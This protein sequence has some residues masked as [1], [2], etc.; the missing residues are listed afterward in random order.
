MADIIKNETPTT[1]GDPA[2]LETP[3]YI[4]QIQAGDTLYDIATHHGIKFRNGVADNTGTT[5]NGTTD[6]EV[7]IPTI[8]ELVQSPIQFVGTVGSEGTIVYNEGITGDPKSGYLVFITVDCTF[9]EI[10]CEARDMA[11]YDGAKWHVVT[12]ENQVEIMGVSQ[13]SNAANV[14][15][16]STAKEVLEVEGKTLKLS[17]DY[18]GV[19]DKLKVSK[20]SAATFDV[21]GT[22]TVKSKF[23]TLTAGE[24]SELTIGEKY[25]LNIPTGLTSGTVSFGELADKSF[26]TK[27]D[28]KITD[29]SL[30]TLKTNAETI[31]ITVE[32]G[33]LTVVATES[34]SGNVITGAELSISNVVTGISEDKNNSKTFL[35]GWHKKATEGD[36]ST[37]TAD[38]KYI[39]TAELGGTTTFFASL[40]D[41]DAQGANTIVSSITGGSVT[42]KFVTG[43]GEGI[44]SVVTSITGGDV[45]LA[46]GTGILTGLSTEGDSG[47]VVSNCTIDGG[48][49]GDATTTNVL[50]SATVNNHVLSFGTSAVVSEQ[51]TYTKPTITTKY[52]TFS[53]SKLQYTAPTIT[54]SNFTTDD[55]KYTA[56]APTYKQL[57]TGT[58]NISATPVEFMWN[59][60]T[61]SAYTPVT[62]D[63]SLNLAKAN[64]TVSKPTITASIPANSVVTGFM[65]EGAL[66]KV[67][68]GDGTNLS[69]TV[70]TDLSTET[71]EFYIVGEDTTKSI[72]IPGAYSLG[73]SDTQ[74]AE[75]ADYVE[76]GAAGEMTTTGSASVDKNTYITDVYFDNKSVSV[77][78]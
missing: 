48:E 58:V 68:V 26:L 51:G 52:K 1:V 72:S 64:I 78:E 44:T 65:T 77:K 76:V 42:G 12:G 20:N 66:P 4:S 49:L 3:N 15:L 10:A 63:I 53:T 5:W 37:K 40:A 73:V 74:P 61:S 27:D 75:G 16:T 50:G 59:T 43:F 71:K 6:L 62:S 69:A 60:D 33:D 24:G 9:N 55:V 41:A 67:S 19:G 54:K 46:T 17:V 13:E 39:E 21:S 45:S 30:P 47:E 70:G 57:Q 8:T 29:G 36:E 35:T 32:S 31:G 38:F 14:V 56:P 2:A 7:I 23:I 22:A 25:S 28:I 18:S 11:I 34:E